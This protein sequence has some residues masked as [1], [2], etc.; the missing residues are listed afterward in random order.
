MLHL[1]EQN[2]LLLKQLVLFALGV[3]A[4]RHVLYRQKYG[5]GRT[6]FVEHAAGIEQHHA[7]A[8]RGEFVLDLISLDGA[9]LW[10]DVL[11]ESPKPRNVPL[12][13]AEIEEQ[14]T[15]CL[16]GRHGEGAVERAARGNHAQVRIEHQKGL[17]YGVDDGLSQ[18]MPM[19]DGGE[20]LRLATPESS[21]LSDLSAR[22]ILSNLTAEPTL[23]D[24]RK[25]NGLRKERCSGC[26]LVALSGTRAVGLAD[27]SF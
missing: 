18:V 5:R 14:S 21:A 4:P 26:R 11:E 27:V 10:N 17:P 3:T 22:W 2:L 15:L 19:R 13:V 25:G 12:A 20:G 8:D 6:I 1:L 9:A 7:P 24:E 16:A 23:P